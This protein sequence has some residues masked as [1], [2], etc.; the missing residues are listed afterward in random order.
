MI[1]FLF[2]LILMSLVVEFVF[3]L[4]HP[5]FHV[6]GGWLNSIIVVIAFVIINTILRL[7]LVIMTLGIGIVFYYLSL[8]LIGLIINAWVILIIGDWFPKT[9][10][11][12]GFWYAFLGGI[13]LVLANYVGKTEAKEKT[14][15]RR[16]T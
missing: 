5:D 3:P 8:G 1:H 10:S 7:I 2:S 16:N 13:L 12:P 4:I 15:E 14:K 9:L 6:V 11:V